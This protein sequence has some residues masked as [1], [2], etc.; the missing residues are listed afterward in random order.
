MRIGHGSPMA[1]PSV[2]HPSAPTDLVASRHKQTSRALSQAP[3]PYTVPG[4]GVGLLHGL[5]R[6]LGEG[7]QGSEQHKAASN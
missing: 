6:S 5:L 2:L 3:Q 7:C 1:A 4:G